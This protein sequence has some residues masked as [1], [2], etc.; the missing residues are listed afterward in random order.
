MRAVQSID[1][2]TA[3]PNSTIEAVVKDALTALH[4]SIPAPGPTDKYSRPLRIYVVTRSGR[5]LDTPEELAALPAPP[6]GMLPVDLSRIIPAAKRTRTGRN[7]AEAQFIKALPPHWHAIKMGWPDFLIVSS[8]GQLA[9]VEVRRTRTRVLKSIQ[10]TCMRLLSR[11]GL[12]CFRWS[13]DTGYDRI[14]V[15]V[16]EEAIIREA[17]SK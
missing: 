1:I 12:P 8:K 11:A 3:A 4:D 6:S 5:H 15:A 14:A 16:P 13:P 17:I 7:K 9:A 10:I 2:T